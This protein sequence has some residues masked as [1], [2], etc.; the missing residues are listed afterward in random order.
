MDLKETCCEGVHLIHLAEDKNQWRAV[1]NTVINLF[2]Y[3]TALFRKDCS[4]SSLVVIAL[5]M[6]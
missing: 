2:C 5:A 6:T 1:V 4:R 3:V